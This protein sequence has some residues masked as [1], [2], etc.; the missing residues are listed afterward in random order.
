MAG[1]PVDLELVRVARSPGGAE[2]FGTLVKRYEKPLY[3]FLLRSLRNAAL[4]EE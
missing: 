4:A 1:D 2:A 3:N